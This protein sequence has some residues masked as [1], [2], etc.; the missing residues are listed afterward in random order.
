MFLLTIKNFLL[1]LLF[2]ENCLS[3]GAPN[4]LFCQGCADALSPVP[5]SCFVCKKLVPAKDGVP[6]GRTCKVCAKNSRIYCFLSPYVYADPR[7]LE[8]IHALKYRRI[9]GLASVCSRLLS[10]YVDKFRVSLPPESLLI[11]IPMH[12]ARERRRGFNQSELIARE[13]S[14][15]LNLKFE[16]KALKKIR[17][18]IPQVD[19]SRGER[20]GNMTGVFAVSDTA[21]VGGKTCILVDD[22]KTTGATLEEAAKVLKGAGAKRIWAITLAH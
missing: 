22:V 10:G 18:T 20:L 17:S 9:R 11:P 1:D 6:S 19:L 5:P 15:I 2:P 14:S 16:G 8:I 13:F 21:L 7:I 4:S 3:C 12:R